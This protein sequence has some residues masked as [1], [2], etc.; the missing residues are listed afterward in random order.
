MT[1][2]SDQPGRSSSVWTTQPS[3]PRHAP[4]TA[5]AVCREAAFLLELGFLSVPD[6]SSVR[7][8]GNAASFVPSGYW[9]LF[10]LL[11]SVPCH[12]HAVEESRSLT[13]DATLAWIL[14]SDFDWLGGL[15]PLT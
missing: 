13:G 5:I 11:E 15:R 8:E 1:E 7:K 3:K 4:G 10:C 9:H 14:S 12:G 6:F 2:V